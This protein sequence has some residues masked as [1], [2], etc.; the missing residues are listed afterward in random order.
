M[1]CMDLHRKIM[2]LTHIL[3]WG[4][5][6]RTK[7]FFVSNCMKCTDQQGKIMFLHLTLM[8]WWQ[9]SRSWKQFC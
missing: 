8:E 9:R 4:G 5:S 7:I 1:K 2:F 6:S 3:P